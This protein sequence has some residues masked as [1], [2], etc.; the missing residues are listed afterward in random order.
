MW[1]MKL[2][3]YDAGWKWY[4]N[5]VETTLSAIIEWGNDRD[6]LNEIL[7]IERN[8]NTIRREE[9]VNALK[10]KIDEAQGPPEVAIKILNATE[11]C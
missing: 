1:K 9:M 5:E 4:K 10:M 3:K 8:L 11:E 7:K 2:E 6:N